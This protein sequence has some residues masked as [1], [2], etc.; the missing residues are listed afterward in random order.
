MT[1][2]FE[3]HDP[4]GPRI[5]YLLWRYPRYSETFIVNEMLALE[6]HGVNI[7]LLTMRPSDDGV[8][9]EAISRVRAILKYMPSPPQKLALRTDED[10]E[11]LRERHPDRLDEV[12]ALMAR[13][14][15][16]TD[17][18]VRAAIY[19]LRWFRKQQLDHVHVHFGKEPA[20]VAML[21]SI[22]G[23]LPYSLT[24]HAYDIYRDNVDRALLDEKIRQ[25]RRVITVSQFNRDYL[26]ANFRHAN[27]ECVVVHYNGVDTASFHDDGGSRE[28]DL[29]IAVGRLIEKKGFVHLI[30]A[31]GR[32]HAGRRPVRCWIAGDGPEAERLL[33]E[34]AQ[35]GLG[36]AVKL[37][38]PL[39]QHE[40]RQ[41]MQRATCFALPC[42]RAIDGNID[43]LPTVLLEAQASGCPAVSTRL[44][45]I[46]EIIEHERSGLLV[47]P[48]DD[49]ALAQAIGRILDDSALAERLAVGGRQRAIERFDA[50][51]N[52]LCLRRIFEAL[53]AERGICV[54]D[55]S[56]TPSPMAAG[57]GDSS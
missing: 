30:R 4:S 2:N 32:L 12:R 33:D 10:L 23:H 45:G 18:H 16:L 31:V 37:L 38:G 13:H 9:H 35:L 57:S 49:Q 50:D 14:A 36:E 39:R 41:L 46:T 26:L 52:G 17:D 21:A 56:A 34:A 55:P 22:L 28:R 20:N 6:R 42:V 44:S 11:R 8:F 15:E 47:E 19:L 5:G 51:R 40:V 54:A 43:A 25:A 53:A 1:F 27:A 48:G 3:Q 29:I 7:S 24:L